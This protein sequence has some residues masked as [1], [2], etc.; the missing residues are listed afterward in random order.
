[1][2]TMATSAHCTPLPLVA[3]SM[4]RSTAHRGDRLMPIT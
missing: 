2:R 4:N 3:R 1:V